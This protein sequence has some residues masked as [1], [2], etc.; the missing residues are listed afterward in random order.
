[1]ML[2]A[3]HQLSLV[4]AAGLLIACEHVKPAA[5]PTPNS[6]ST[7]APAA[8]PLP[9][10]QAAPAPSGRIV[11]AD[12]RAVTL[13]GPFWGPRLA[14]V[15][16]GTLRANRHQCD[17]TGRIANF[18]RAAAK[19]AGDPNPGAYE[20]L[21]FNDSDVY[22]MVEGWCYVLASEPEA[23]RRAVLDR[24]LDAL[25]AAIAKAQHPDG[26]INTYYTLKAGVE[27]RFTR[28]EWD[29]ETYCMGHLIEAGVAHHLATGK[30]SLLGV[31][32][33]AADFLDDLYDPDGFTAP[34][35]H[36]ELEL[37]LVRLADL[38]GETKYL[39]LA[40]FLIDQRGRPH[41][42]LDGS[43]YGPW[44]DYAQDHLPVT[45]QHEAAGHA[46]R[47]G[48]M[49][50]AMA[51]LARRGRGA[52]A[53][54]LHALW[55]D[56]TERRIFV[57][58]GIGPSAH[59]EGFTSPYD[60]PTLSAYQE[61]CASIALCM[62]AHAMFLLTGDGAYMEQ[63]ERTLYNAVLAGVSLDGDQFFYV[64]PL[65]SRGGHARRDWYAC[66]CCPPNVLRFLGSLGQYAYATRGDAV[67]VNLFMEGGATLDL[68]EGRT[69]RVE[70][71][72][73]YPF[74]GE[75]EI[76]VSNP[77]DRPITLAVRAGGSRAGGHG[78]DADGY[79]RRTIDPG[80]DV[81]VLWSV[82]METRRVYADPRVKE[83]AGRVAIMRGPL[84]YAVE[85]ADPAL[86]PH[87]LVLPI[88]A[89]IGRETRPDG[90][91]TLH[92]QGLRAVD[93]ASHARDDDALYRAG[94]A[95]VPADLTLTPYFMWANTG[96][97]RMA[98]WLPEGVHALG[99][100]PASGITAS[101]S[102]VGH[103]DGLAALFDRIEPVSSNDHDVP[104]FTFWPHKG[105]ANAG[106]VAGEN[107]DR[108]GQEWVRYDFASPRTLSEVS[109]YWF[110]DT[111]RGQCRVPASWSL[112]W[113]DG[114]TWR[115]ITLAPHAA[116]D[117]APPASPLGTARDAFNTVRFERVTTPALR[118]RV[119]LQENFS[120][121]ILE[122]RVN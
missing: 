38:T 49:Y 45:E 21:L 102:F 25:I 61:T 121:G 122:I 76:R 55:R 86:D 51:E 100:R 95:L 66:A 63:F 60:I 19:L 20:G 107:A 77:T 119:T 99:P 70:Q 40:E 18:E 87:A 115:E 108:A 64:N 54:A 91:V 105:V 12:Y 104:R 11:P 90:V 24:D 41:R 57:T 27:N 34:P 89:P 10:A 28:E 84:V 65:A 17:I 13:D 6:T 96:P 39:D 98:V 109:V 71:S 114:E 83:S 37:A 44:G 47:A 111:G 43:T 59:N 16:E 81:R 78:I 62:W 1:M 29:H 8:S 2:H 15:R 31:A 80:A 53:P 52:Y 118:I 116:T 58:G 67:Y 33:R 110:D 88:N 75:V 42:K 26:Y 92:A 35:G 72:T 82:P 36:Q 14:S 50:T 94:P 9:A 69:I 73:A 112:E 46:V 74:D 23:D 7:S 4:L 30:R 32:L 113:L 5:A 117:A 106:P 48:Y 79:A 56:V 103:G 97:S 3:T 101:A 120:A 93:S 85:S 68:G 22:K